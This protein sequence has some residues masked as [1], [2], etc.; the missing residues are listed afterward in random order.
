MVRNLVKVRVMGTRTPRERRKARMRD[1]TRKRRMRDFRRCG[2]LVEGFWLLFSRVVEGGL[3]A[4]SFC[5]VFIAL[6]S[7]DG[8]LW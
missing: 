5:A 2:G 4:S 3:T 7:G 6:I 8:G 1:I